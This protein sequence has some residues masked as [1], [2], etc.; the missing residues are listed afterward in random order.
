[1][2]YHG[3]NAVR[4]DQKPLTWMGC[5]GDNTTQRQNMIIRDFHAGHP[6]TG[7]L[8]KNIVWKVSFAQ[9]Y[10]HLK[11]KQVERKMQLMRYT[12][13]GE[14]CLLL[15]RDEAGRTS[16]IRPGRNVRLPGPVTTAAEAAE[17]TKFYPHQE[18]KIMEV[19]T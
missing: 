8:I 19:S 3:E 13:G 1:M 16:S 17:A 9:V 18:Y 11:Q 4:A 2:V 10:D 7:P 14:G 5:S 15:D 6:Y 12:Y